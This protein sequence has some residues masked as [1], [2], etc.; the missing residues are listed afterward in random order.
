[1]AA[2]KPK[3]NTVYEL[4]GIDGETIKLTLAYRHLYQ[5]RAKH[6]DQYEEFNRI[7]MKGAKDYFDNLS[8]LYTAYLCEA[9]AETGDTSGCRSFD[10]FLD[11]LPID[12]Q[13]VMRAVGM[14]I[15]PK[16]T[17]ASAALS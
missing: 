9:I 14:L 11:M 2:N 7:M 10:E 1:M 12:N 5:L 6:R 13:E 3:L 4:E 15:A 16:K 17:M 8:L